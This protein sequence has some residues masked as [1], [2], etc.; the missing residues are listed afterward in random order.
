[1]VSESCQRGVWKFSG[2]CLEGVESVWKVSG[3]CLDG[4]W[5]VSV[6]CLDD[7]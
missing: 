6:D 4:D 1:M 2:G 5:M 7:I 3:L